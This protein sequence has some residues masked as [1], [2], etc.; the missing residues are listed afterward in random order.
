M[1]P[2]YDPAKTYEDNF[3]HGPFGDFASPQKYIEKNHAKNTF[4]GFPV[5][6]PFGIPA[7]PL[8]NSRYIKSAFEM[9]F[10]VLVYK[11][12]RN[13][14]FPCNEF[15]N[16]LYLDIKGDLTLKRADQPVVGSAKQPSSGSLS[17]TNSFGNP[18]KGPEF[19]VEDVKKAL[20]YQG[21]G[22][23]L[24][25]SIVGTIKE[26][27]T[28]EDYYNDFA[29]AAQKGV[30][31]GVKVIEINYSC[32]N[33]VSEGVLCYSPKAVLS[34]AQKVKARVGDIPVISKLGYYSPSQ[35]ALF[36]EIVKSIQPYSA[37]FAV[38]NTIPA[39]I[40]DEK[41]QQALPGEGRLKSGVC[42]TA[43]KWAG[44]EMVR[45]LKEFREKNG[46]SFEI[47]GVGGVIKPQ[48]YTAYRDAG[49]DCVM[50]A[51]GAMWNPLLAQQIKQLG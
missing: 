22:Q 32:P 29:D 15:P 28:E 6:L 35:Q 47:V 43:V 10:D 16:V 5:N 38:I 24:A 25:L 3:E 27:G 20:S 44:L 23:L 1:I 48:D 17:I 2:F 39:P 31:A 4:L 26:G 14:V 49:A 21:P 34:I 30:E 40:V 7:G 11:T 19:W 45:K 9:G 8:L 42:G 50:S 13:N 12:Q 18:S 41:G 33:V 46:S 36:E 51:T 37:A